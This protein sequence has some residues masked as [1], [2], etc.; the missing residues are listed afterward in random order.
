MP[1]D[2]VGNGKVGVGLK[3]YAGLWGE[4]FQAGTELDVDYLSVTDDAHLKG[5]RA[6]VE[7]HDLCLLFREAFPTL[8]S[9]S[10]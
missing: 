3:R 5:L 10:M 4:A 6:Y 1:R 2:Y 9:L 7:S 8:L